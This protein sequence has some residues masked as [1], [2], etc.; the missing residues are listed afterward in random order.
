MILGIIIGILATVFVLM[1]IGMYLEIMKQ[2]KSLQSGV[3]YLVK[4]EYEFEQS[5]NEIL[6]EAQ[7]KEEQFNRVSQN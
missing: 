1:I 5:E 7:R 2:I 6:K 3:V 4:R